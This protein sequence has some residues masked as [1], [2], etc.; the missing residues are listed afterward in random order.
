MN[1]FTNRNHYDIILFVTVIERSF[2]MKHQISLR[3][4]ILFS[5]LIVILAG[6]NSEKNNATKNEESDKIKVYTALY[7]FEFF[8]NEIGGDYV[9]VTNMMPLGGDA[10]TFEPTSKELTQVA[11][12][13]LFIESG[14]GIEMFVE[15]LEESMKNENVKFV[16]ATRGIELL[17]VNGKEEDTHDHDDHG[18]EAHEDEH[19]DHDGHNHGNYDPHVWLDPILSIEMA[20]KIKNELT[21]LDPKHKETFEKNF[22]SLKKTLEEIDQEFKT[23]TE[24]APKKSFIVSHKAYGYWADR[25]DLEQIGI[26]G[27]SSTNEPSQK[28][29]KEIIEVAK[30][31]DLNYVVYEQNVTPKVAKVIETEINAKT[32]RLHNLASLTEEDKNENKNYIDLMKENIK[33]IETALQ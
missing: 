3:L 9:E 23:V 14:T 17:E 12:A 8:T 28:Q 30:E 25:Y 5:A 29:L 2:I 33:T 13:D 11:N 18:E 6:C 27:L 26:A 24:K 31:K 16:N 1:S 4:I 32:L 15:K 20:E 7:A 10:H 21:S 19:D 22:E